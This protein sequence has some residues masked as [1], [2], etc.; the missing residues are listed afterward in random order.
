VTVVIRTHLAAAL[1]VHG[2]RSVVSKIVAVVGR[3]VIVEAT[4]ILVGGI[5]VT[6]IIIIVAV[7]IA[8]TSML[9]ANPTSRLA[10]MVHDGGDCWT[11]ETTMTAHENET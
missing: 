9:A 11:L 3:A 1:C 5:I 7:M 8:R 6:I 2:R 10:T 4:A